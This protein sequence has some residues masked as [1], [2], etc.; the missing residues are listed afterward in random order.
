MIDHDMVDVLEAYRWRALSHARA[1]HLACHTVRENSAW[2]QSENDQMA[3]RLQEVCTSPKFPEV[4]NT[5]VH[6][7]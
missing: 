5:C 2:I 1:H 6:P 3:P 7:Q 4:S